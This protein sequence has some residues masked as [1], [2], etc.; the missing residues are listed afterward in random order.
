VQGRAEALGGGG[1]GGT[2][3]VLTP[4]VKKAADLA[5][6]AE[7]AATTGDASEVTALAGALAKGLN[8]VRHQAASADVSYPLQLLEEDLPETAA[9]LK[10][11]GTATATVLSRTDAPAPR[12]LAG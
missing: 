12:Q 7:R 10:R 8:R 1:F 9:G 6:A 11:T 3:N 4:L 2:G 5:D